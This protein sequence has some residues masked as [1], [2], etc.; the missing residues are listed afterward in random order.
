M[1]VIS[2]ELVLGYQGDCLIEM[3]ERFTIVVRGSNLDDIST[4]GH[5]II[6]FGSCVRK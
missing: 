5:M 4:S 1:P 2:A 3:E 6:W